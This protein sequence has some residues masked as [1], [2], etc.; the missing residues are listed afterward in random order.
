MIMSLI[1]NGM[2][3]FLFLQGF[4]FQ[5]REGILKTYLA[6]EWLFFKKRERIHI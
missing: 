1:L 2:R 6:E 4:F 5:Q 3:N